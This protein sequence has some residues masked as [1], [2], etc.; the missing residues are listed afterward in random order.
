MKNFIYIFFIKNNETIFDRTVCRFGL[1]PLR[2]KQRVEEL[3]K[4]GHEAFYTIGTLPKC[5]FFV[6]F[7]PQ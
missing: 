2:A 3:E 4:R 7:D 5:D 6:E 1:G